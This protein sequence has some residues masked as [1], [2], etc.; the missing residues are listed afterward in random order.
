MEIWI[1]QKSLQNRFDINTL[2]GRSG[3]F[4]WFILEGTVLFGLGKLWTESL[5]DYINQPFDH[6]N[7]KITYLMHAAQRLLGDMDVIDVDLES[8]WKHQ[9]LA[10]LGLEFEFVLEAKNNKYK[11]ISDTSLL[12]NASPA[13]PLM[14]FG[15]N[16]IG[17]SR[18]QLG[19]G[20]DIRM[21]AKALEAAAIPYSVYE[22]QADLLID[23]NE[24]SLDLQLTESMPYQFNM[25]CLTGMETL[26]IS[27]E[28]YFP[29]LLQRYVNI[30]YWPWEFERWPLIFQD[31]YQIVDEIWAST[32]FTAEAYKADARVNVE[33]MPMHVDVSPG[34]GLSRKAFDLPTEPFLFL[35]TFDV[36]SSLQRKNPIAILKAF[37]GA[38]PKDDF[39]VALVV[40]LKR[41]GSS[42][43]PAL[44]E[45]RSAAKADN[46]I[47]IIEETF[48]RAQLLDLSRVCNSYVSL[49]RCEG[50]GR[51]MAE[52]MLLGKTV[53]ATKYSGNLDFCTSKTSL[54][55]DAE[56]IPVMPDEYEHAVGQYWA[57]PSFSSAVEALQQAVTSWKPDLA[58][59]KEIERRYSTKVVGDNYRKRLE[60]LRQM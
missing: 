59:I 35:F 8:W 18:G 40:K 10:K 26:R 38:F 7:P 46:R 47:I 12:T 33:L 13:A 37:Q 9:G 44:L 43:A 50:F 48:P 25:F 42:W 41:G 60:A 3:L 54:L 52:A 55:V 36:G 29:M 45:L 49:H 56:L 4:W 16:L 5:R 20:E 28:D 19:I 58:S 24:N 39:S 1:Q 34:A 27:V 30:G 32:K 53:I 51:G 6:G 57:N 14:P 22:V 21:A 17:F 23:S 11:Q 15:V 2:A 31:N